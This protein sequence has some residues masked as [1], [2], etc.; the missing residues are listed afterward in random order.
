METG[1]QGS[2]PESGDCR[3]GPPRIIP[4]RSHEGGHQA[5]RVKTDKLYTGECYKGRMDMVWSKRYLGHSTGILTT[6]LVGW[7][8]LKPR[9]TQKGFERRGD[10][11]R[12]VSF[13]LPGLGKTNERRFVRHGDETGNGK[14]GLQS[15]PPAVLT[16]QKQ[17]Q[18]AAEAHNCRKLTCVRVTGL[19]FS[20]PGDSELKMAPAAEIRKWE[21]ERA[22]KKMTLFSA[23][24]FKHIRRELR[25]KRLVGHF[26]LKIR[27]VA[28]L[29]VLQLT[30][31]F[32]LRVRSS[33]G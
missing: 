25:A 8:W 13:R 3:R 22:Q 24:Y 31:C 2:E 5:G 15:N 33:D 7:W 11:V 20:I 16:T 30:G 21:G 12:L 6:I 9:E 27:S 4:A 10:R 18:V 19:V 26:S 1:I 32:P 29:F 14:A 23:S 28:Q 17:Q